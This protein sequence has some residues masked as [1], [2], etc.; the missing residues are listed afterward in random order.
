M[1]EADEEAKDAALMDD[2][3]ALLR[4]AEIRML[5]EEFFADDLTPPPYS[6][7]WSTDDLRRWFE[8]GGLEEPAA[9]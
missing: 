9:V 8:S 3:S 7:L 1:D 2:I 6:I 4:E 5:Q